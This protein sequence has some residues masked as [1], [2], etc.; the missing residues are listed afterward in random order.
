MGRV[1]HS[2]TNDLYRFWPGAHLEDG[3]IFPRAQVGVL[4]MSCDLIGRSIQAQIE[5]LPDV[6]ML[7]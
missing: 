5:N 6:Q 2:Y 4:Q 1:G 3:F 7:L